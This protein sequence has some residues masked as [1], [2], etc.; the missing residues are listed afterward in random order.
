MCSRLNFRQEW[1]CLVKDAADAIET[2]YSSED[3]LFVVTDDELT[4]IDG[5]VMN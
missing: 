2:M 3:P 5:E 4:M 1:I